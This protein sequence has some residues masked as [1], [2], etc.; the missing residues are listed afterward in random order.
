MFRQ[1]RHCRLRL[2]SV[3]ILRYCNIRSCEVSLYNNT[4][5]M[6]LC[7]LLH[8]NRMLNYDKHLHYL[9][10]RHNHSLCMNGYVHNSILHLRRLH[11]LYLDKL[12]VHSLRHMCLLHLCCCDYNSR[13]SNHNSRHSRSCLANNCFL[14][15]YHS[16]N[17]L[18]QLE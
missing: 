12:D 11:R 17:R 6:L 14:L 2:L 8:L 5:R 3:R 7:L 15:E 16:S 9:R 18:Y 13:R 1:S 4:Y 10:R